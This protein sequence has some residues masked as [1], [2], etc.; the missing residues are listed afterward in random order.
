MEEKINIAEI[1]K[2]KPQGTKLYNW[3]YNTNVELDTIST[4]DKETAI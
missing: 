1:L 4:T 3:L 2:N